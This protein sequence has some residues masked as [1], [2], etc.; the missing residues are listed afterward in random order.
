MRTISALPIFVHLHAKAVASGEAHRHGAVVLHGRVDHVLQF[1]L[2]FGRHEHDIR[3]GTQIRDVE[4]AL[5]RAPIVTY[6][7][8]A[9]HGEYHRQVLD[10]A[11][12]YHLVVGTL[13]EGRVDGQPGLDTLG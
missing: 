8:A 12:A 4:D 5:V 1:V 11:V 2:V 3:D 10:A 9:I 6:D 13:Q 7:A